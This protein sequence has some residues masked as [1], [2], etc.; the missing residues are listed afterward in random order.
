MRALVCPDSFKGTFSAVEVAAAVGAGIEDAGG[1][2]DLCPAAD[3]GE[4]TATTVRAAIGG[5][6]RTVPAHDPLGRP[7]EASFVLVEDGMTAVVDT[8]AA[9]GLPLVAAAERDAEAASS[10][11][12]GELIAAAVEAGARRVLLAAGGSAMTDGGLGAIE[13]LRERGFVGGGGRGTGAGAG[14]AEGADGWA[15]SD[16]TSGATPAADR[17]GGAGDVV[18]VVLCDVTTRFEDAARVF[19]PQKGADAAAVERLAER[20]GRIAAE[21][22]RDPRG[23]PMTGCAG[24]LSGGL[25]AAFGAELR[26]GAEF[27]LDLLGFEGRLA[28][29]DLVVAGEG[30]IDSQSLEG[31]IVGQI[32]ARCEAAGKPLHV[33]VGQ[34][35][36]E[37]AAATAAGIASITEA[38][39]LA[40]L[41]ATGQTLAT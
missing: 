29:A 9:S 26:P 10:Y 30:R 25:W 37:P 41:R 35:A 28:A 38:G 20:L 22:P 32:A 5:E 11:G 24:G 34:D 23:V 4:G 2:V 15:R 17:R 31:K 21:L 8:A 40:A 3:G 27:V 33:V 36:F 13:A 19:G 18:L 14:R 1:E 39:T 16:G 6:V 12:T 7:I